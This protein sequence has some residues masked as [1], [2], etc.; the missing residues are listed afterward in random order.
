MDNASQKG[1][2]RRGLILS[3]GA[4]MMIFNGLIYAWSIFVAPLESAFGWNRGQT[5]L[6][7]TLSMSVSI[8]GQIAGG[9]G[10]SRGR[11]GPMLRVAA[12]LLTLGF[13]WASAI[14]SLP[15][16]YVSYGILCGFAVGISYNTVI[17]TVL[18]HFPERT[19]FASGILLMAFGLG[20]L[21]LGSATTSLILHYGW[22]TAFRAL[23]VGFGAVTFAGSLIVV[24]ADRKVKEEGSSAD[25][26]P[27]DMIREGPYA[28]FFIWAVLMSSTGLLILGHAAPYAAE[29]GASVELAALSAGFISIF[30]GISRL[31]F[32]HLYDRRGHVTAMFLT[33]TLYIIATAG[34][35]AA[36]FIGSLWIL[37]PSYAVLGLAYGGGP[38]TVS[39]YIKERYGD[40][41]YG[42]NLGITNLNIVVASFIG[43][44]L[45]G[46]LRS[47]WQSYLP[48]FVLMFM[49]VSVAFALV[50][51]RRDNIADTRSVDD[52]VKN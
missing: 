7:F 40:G 25:P 43:P 9:H 31:I 17:S 5:S 14:N 23:A 10:A 12:V 11:Q 52:F 49:F 38:V 32:G 16:L 19:G 36:Y 13:I 8:L 20:S 22:R 18:S 6:V 28:K 45:A 26:G 27:R 46:M 41:H 35:V 39:T 44:L 1:G 50:P 48:A 47:T 2:I 33:C 42:V 29:L 34:L 21:V 4:L 24:P 37:F 51:H 30:N 15:P 3:F